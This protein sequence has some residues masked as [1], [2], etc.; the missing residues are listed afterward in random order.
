MSLLVKIC[1]LK[2]AEDVAAAVDAGAGAIGFV[3][4]ESK[5]RVT[6]TQAAIAASAA[7]EGV[8]R[9]AVMLHPEAG[10]WLDVLEAFKPDVLQTDHDDFDRLD[11]PARVARWPVY[12]EGGALPDGTI[13][14]TFVYEGRSSGRGETVDWERAADVAGRGRM[15]LAGGLDRDNVARAILTVR[16]FGVDVSSAVESAPGEKD[17]AR[18]REFVMAAKAAEQHL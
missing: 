10:E 1:G 11:V 5:R 2:R 7:P 15:V 4:A 8:L 3:F 6:P 14:D 13:S 9:V 12:R 17:P 18:I 16:P